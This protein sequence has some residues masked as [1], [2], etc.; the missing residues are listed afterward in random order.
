M[1]SRIIYIPDIQIA[2]FQEVSMEIT[3][4]CFKIYS[5]LLFNG[6]ILDVSESISSIFSAASP[7]VFIVLKDM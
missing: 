2:K 4:Q 3:H 5:K 1:K 6:T 7:I